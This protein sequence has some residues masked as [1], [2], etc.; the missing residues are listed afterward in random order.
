MPMMVNDLMYSL[1][2]FLMNELVGMHM[3]EQGLFHWAICVQLI[4]IVL[5]VVDV[6]E[7]AIL[8]IGSM[9]IGEKD[10]NGFSMLVYKLVI[11]IVG[12]AGAV[13]LVVCCFPNEVAALF[14]NMDVSAQWPL[15]VR[16][17]SLMLVPHALSVFL[18]SFFQVLE[19][20]WMGMLFSFLQT[21]CMVT[22]LWAFLCWAPS[23]AWWSFPISAFLLLAMQVV[24]ICVLWRKHCNHRLLPDEDSDARQEFELSVEYDIGAVSDAVC[25]VSRFLEHCGLSAAQIMAV[26]ICCE[27]LMLNIVCHQSH[28]NN[29][30]MDLY[31]AVG[32]KKICII[33]KDAGRPF[34]PVLPASRNTLESFDEKLGLA[35]VNNVC[36]T[37]SHKYMYGQNVVF[38]EFIRE[39]Q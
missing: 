12:L 18:R 33:L 15:A 17:F 10:S 27:E 16:V 19:R 5:F 24:F 2:L 6:A 13:T 23:S 1:M 14:S 3:G 38:A 26:N 39:E 34:N 36:T 20:R 22:G 31:I 7:G 37:L 9:L 8:S 29:P 4:M 32:G 30:Y 11:M 25:Q 21:L 28:K 35:L